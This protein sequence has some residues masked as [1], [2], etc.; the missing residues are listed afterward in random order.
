MVVTEAPQSDDAAGAQTYWSLAGEANRD[1][2]VAESMARGLT[3]E[4][5]LVEPETAIGRAVRLLGGKRRIVR[6]VR[7]G[8][9]AVIEEELEVSRDRLRH[10]DGPTIELDKIGR[11]VFTGATAEEAQQ[12]REAYANALDTLDT[13]DMSHWLLT[14]LE[15]LNAVGLRKSGGIYYVPPHR[16][17]AW[18]KFIEVLTVV[19]PQSVVYTIPTVRMTADGARAILDSLTSEVEEQTDKLTADVVSGQLG[20]RGLNNRGDQSAALLA[21]V[22]QYESVLGQRLERLRTIIGK[23][24][25]DVAG[26][27]LAA[28]AL[29]DEAGS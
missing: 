19:A 20:L 22:S 1:K 3:H 23:L 29:E 28:E 16:M 15:R 18:R 7:K 26:A 25:V 9:W 10:W 14:A 27:R 11:P 8:K 17:A 2:L 13:T 24:D 6:S 12:V 5:R 4:P 21:K